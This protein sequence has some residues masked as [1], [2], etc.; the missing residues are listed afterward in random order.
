MKLL[1]RSFEKKEKMREVKEVNGQTDQ[2]EERGQEIEIMTGV[3]GM[4][5]SCSRQ[6]DT[7]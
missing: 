2:T 1:N 5:K 4:E 7:F 6:R 3:T